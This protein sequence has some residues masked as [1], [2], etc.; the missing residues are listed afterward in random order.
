MAYARYR[1]S[2]LSQQ[3]LSSGPVASRERPKVAIII[4]AGAGIGVNVAK[5]FA[6]AGM[7][8]VLCRRSDNEGLQLAVEDI[9]ADGGQAEGMLVDMVKPGAI[10]DTIA[11]V[12]A[13]IGEIHVA[14]Y[15]LGAQIGNRSLESLSL[16]QFELGWRMGCEGLFRLAKAV[17][18][19]MVRRG[20]G[21]ILC[22]SATSAMRGNAGQHSHAASI[23]GRRLLLQSLNHE[24]GPKGIHLCH[25][26][27]DSPVN[28]P[29]TLGKLVGPEAFKQ[30]QM[31]GDKIVQPLELAET[32]HHV[33]NQHRSAWTFEIDIRPY[34]QTAWFNS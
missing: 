20:G 29:D 15:N 18:P 31:Q 30:I 22:T 14:I 25:I 19:S 12:E 10:E 7:Y 32:Y 27:V 5:R 23:G 8:A 4:G 34:S 9:R 26:V 17:I 21:T 24:F 11:K 2:V 28:A 6:K 16:R 3:I 13:E 33:A 1:V